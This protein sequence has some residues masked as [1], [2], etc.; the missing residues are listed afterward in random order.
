MVSLSGW[1]YAQPAWE[2]HRRQVLSMFGCSQCGFSNRF[3]NLLA[4][5]AAFGS[6]QPGVAPK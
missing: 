2:Q 4:L 3:C 6:K 1:H 5:A